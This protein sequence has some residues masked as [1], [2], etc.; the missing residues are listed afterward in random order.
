M[1]SKP[2]KEY[3][4]ER[5]IQREQE[6]YLIGVELDKRLFQEY[7]RA[8]R[9]LRK[10]IRDFYAKYGKKHDLAYEDVVK[11]LSA[12][13]LQEWKRTLEE[14]LAEINAAT[15]PKVREALIAQLDALSTNSQISRL[16]ALIADTRVQLD[17]LYDR[18][19]Q[20]MTNGFAEIYS[21]SYYHKHFDLQCRAGRLADVVKLTPVM[22]SDA[23][24]YPW[25]GAMFSD[26]LW[27]NKEALLFNIRE[28]ITQGLIQG[29][30]LP[31][32]SKQLSAKMG[33]SYKV[34]E[35]LVRTETNHLHNRADLAAYDAAGIA[36]YEFMATLDAR[37]CAQCGAMDGKHFPVK[38]AQPGVNFPPLHPNDRCTTVEYDPDDAADWA[39]SGE[40]MPESMTYEEWSDQLGVYESDVDDVARRAA[41]SLITGKKV[42]P[43]SGLDPDLRKA[44]R[45]GLN[46]A[47][48]DVA[49]VLRNTYRTVD[50]AISKNAG[51]SQ[52][53]SLFSKNTVT[54]GRK[55]SADTIAHELFHEIDVANGNISL[56]L[57]QAIAQ[58]MV[59]LNVAS[60]GDIL[61]YLQA[62][63]PGALQTK[64]KGRVKLKAPYRGIADIL[65]G[66]SGG[67]E[68]YGYGHDPA[69]WK[70]LGN[71]EAEAWAQFGR[72]YYVSDPDVVKM[73]SSLFPNLDKHAKLLLNGVI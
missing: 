4:I 65:N 72:T 30:S 3:W 5:S 40:E 41:K 2:S 64:R 29:K 15:D 20:E 26:R 71:L 59:A 52:R 35:R 17:Q 62:N 55:A 54:L 27:K 33:Q 21:E 12:K 49:K 53:R 50:Y 13:E 58:D 34:A 45:A 14:Y 11:K 7:D 31:E 19:R 69:Y 66:M 44:F 36:E 24:S 9:A 16:D 37:T 70:I 22:I 6:A 57:S 1:A 18:C 32:T 42:V 68:W 60:N 46:T 48:P 73:F 8:T 10:T 39:A 38:D 51:S 61:A 67:N 28:I 25:S 23:V 56:Q 47:D 63:Y 43:F